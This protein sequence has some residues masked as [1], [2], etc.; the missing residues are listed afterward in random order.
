MKILIADDHVALRQGV[1]HILAEALPDAKFGESGTTPETLDR[2]RR[3][4]W[5]VLLLDITLPG[6]GGLDVLEEAHR[7]FPELPV[8][9]FSST[10]EEQLAIRV[11]KCGA[12]GYLNKQSV[13][14]ELVTAVQKVATGG[15]YVSSSLAGHLVDAVG[16]SDCPPHEL[17]STREFQVFEFMVRGHSIKEVASEFSISPKTVSTFRCRVMEKLR[18]HSDVEL[19]HYAHKHRL[20]GFGAQ[21]A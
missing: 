5:D 11:F 21:D 16:H 8:L 1:K 12:A 10:P 3:E 15:R 18:I 14:E 9:V 7:D 13:A 17:L 6:R 20:F 2:L 4:P 19:A